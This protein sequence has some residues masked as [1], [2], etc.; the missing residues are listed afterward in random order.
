MREK[1][2]PV[3]LKIEKKGIA[4]QNYAVYGFFRILGETETT[5]S[6]II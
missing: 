1:G 2:Y 3:S 6:H 4:V 5:I